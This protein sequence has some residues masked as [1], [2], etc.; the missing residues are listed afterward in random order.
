AVRRWLWDGGKG[1]WK[2]ERGE[3]VEPT[4]QPFGRNQAGGKRR[5]EA[6][7]KPAES[8]SDDRHSSRRCEHD[9]DRL[10][11]GDGIAEVSE[12]DH[13]HDERCC[14][15]QQTVEPQDAARG[16]AHGRVSLRAISSWCQSRMAFATRSGSSHIGK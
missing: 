12:R 14:C 11:G 9:A 7:R 13:R 1:G 6:E 4:E 2:N 10:C 16:A 15:E 3:K 5:R 8:D